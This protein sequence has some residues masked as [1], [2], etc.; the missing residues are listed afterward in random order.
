MA[1]EG[2]RKKIDQ[3]VTNR[4]DARQLKGLKKRQ[5]AAAARLAEPPIVPAGQTVPKDVELPQ[6]RSSV[7][8][9]ILAGEN[10]DIN[11]R[12]LNQHKAGQTVTVQPDKLPLRT[13]VEITQRGGEKVTVHTDAGGGTISDTD[14]KAQNLARAKAAAIEGAQ[15]VLAKPAAY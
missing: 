10:P 4:E 1:F 12:G 5:A 9:P 13:P 8:E 2:L 14:L 7:G 6:A 3:F 15:A 11:R